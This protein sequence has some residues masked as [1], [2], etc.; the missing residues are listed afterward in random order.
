[1]HFE[2]MKSAVPPNGGVQSRW[3]SNAQAAV[4]EIPPQLFQMRPSQRTL[5]QGSREVSDQFQDAVFRQSFAI[6]A[7][8]AIERTAFINLCSPG[9]T[10][11]GPRASQ[12]LVSSSSETSILINSQRPSDNLRFPEIE[13]GE[14]CR[15]ED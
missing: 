2:A 12:A 4:G 9:G 15:N 7:V 6:A 1:L 13:N 11:L 3:F 8:T 10:R 14:F 5:Q